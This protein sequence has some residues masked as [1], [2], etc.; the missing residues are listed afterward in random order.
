MRGHEPIIT[1]RRQG[2]RPAVVFLNDFPCNTDWTQFGDH[3]TVCV[4]GDNP[5]LADLRFLIRLDVSIC[6]RDESRARGFM[7]A[8][9]QAGAATVAASAPVFADGYWREGWADV[10]SREA[11]AAHG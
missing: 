3:A 9:I 6:S 2:Q 10:W 11:E 1:M 4:A 5:E 8:A 7:Q